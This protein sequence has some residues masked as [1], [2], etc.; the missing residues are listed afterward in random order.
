MAVEGAGAA[1]GQGCSGVANVV[2]CAPPDGTLCYDEA[3][4]RA[5]AGFRALYP[6][7]AFLGEDTGEVDTEEFED[8]ELAAAKEAMKAAGVLQ[9]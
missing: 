3:V 2:V 7:L 6:E 9:E 4:R 5:K 8:D 1:G